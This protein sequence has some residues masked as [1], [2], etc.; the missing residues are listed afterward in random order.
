MAIIICLLGTI[1]CSVVLALDKKEEYTVLNTNALEGEEVQLNLEEDFTSSPEELKVD[2]NVER[3]KK[4]AEE[5]KAKDAELKRKEEEERRKKE[6]EE[7]KKQLEAERIR[8]EQERA[9][10]RLRECEALISEAKRLAERKKYKDALNKLE[11]AKSLKVADK[12]AELDDLYQTI[13]KQK[14]ENTPFK[15]LFNFLKTEA[16]E[17]MKG[18]N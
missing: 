16:D 10:K 6:E 15:K 18:E 9:Q 13:N 14:S 8:Q 4:I 17:M 11:E 1:Y 5:E 12:E 3:L 7:R 2:V